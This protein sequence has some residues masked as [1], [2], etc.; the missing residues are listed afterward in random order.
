MNK[1]G[2]IHSTLNEKNADKDDRNKNIV[3][4]FMDHVRH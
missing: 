3:I 4:L 1:L 2:R